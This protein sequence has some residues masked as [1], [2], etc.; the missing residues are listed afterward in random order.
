MQDTRVPAIPDITIDF[1]TLLDYMVD[2]ESLATLQA[3]LTIDKLPKFSIP[4]AGMPDR[5]SPARKLSCVV[6]NI[7]ACLAFLTSMDNLQNVAVIRTNCAYWVMGSA[8]EIYAAQLERSELMKQESARGAGPTR[9]ART[10]IHHVLVCL[11]RERCIRDQLLN[12]DEAVDP[13]RRK[14]FVLRMQRAHKYVKLTKVYPEIFLLAV[15]QVCVTRVDK[16]S[17]QMLDAFQHDRNPDLL[18]SIQSISASLQPLREDLRA[19]LDEI[20]AFLSV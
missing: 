5:L 1:A 17:F 4:N 13:T 6:V 19:R 18:R 20:P 10:Q 16:V 9:H 14:A 7:Q 8:F 12:P 3:L 2:F 15:P 11:E